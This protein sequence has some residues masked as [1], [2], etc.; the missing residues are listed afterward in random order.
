GRELR[1][2]TGS[3]VETGTPLIRLEPIADDDGGASPA[4]AAAGVELDLP[5]EDIVETVEN[6]IS[7]GLADLSAVLL[8]FDVDP[9]DD[10]RTL[11]DYLAARDKA[12]GGSD[13]VTDEVELVRLFADFAELSR[14]RPAD[15]EL[16]IENRVH[17]P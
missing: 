10:G 1:V 5:A 3:Q 15:E 7:R 2:T 16:H 14:N 13:V 9:L 4:L 11:S 12:A 17:S 8:G 6:R